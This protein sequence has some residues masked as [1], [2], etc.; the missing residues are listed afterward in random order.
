MVQS[1]TPSGIFEWIAKS[2]RV[3]TSDTA[4]LRFAEMESQADY[5]LPEIHQSLDHNDSRHWHHRG[6]IWDYISSLEGAKRVLDVGPGDGWP[7]L[8]L[9]RHFDEIVGIEPVQK[10]LDVC[11]AN[12]KKMKVRNVQFEQ[13]SACDMSF[14]SNSFDGAVAATSIEQTPDPLAALR[15]VHRVLKVGG[16]F[17]LSYEA[18]ENVAEPVRETVSIKAGAD[19]SYQI[20]YI[21]AWTDKAEERG[22]MINVI[23]RSENSKKRFMLWAERCKDD[24]F[25]HRDPRLERGLSRTIKG[26]RQAEVV[27]CNG[28]K[29]K[30]F[31][32]LPLIKSLSRIGFTNIRRVA[33]GGWP[34]MQSA[35]ELI[36]SR[37]IQAASPLMEE[38]CR[39][40]ARVGILLPTETHGQLIMTKRRAK[41]KTEVKEPAKGKA[42][43]QRKSAT[44]KTGVAKSSGTGAKTTKKTTKKVTKKTAGKTAAKTTR[45]TKP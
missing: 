12:A 24:S 22:Y 1:A 38:I 33:G 21:V 39:G 37:R 34:A 20:D 15:E 14:R 31:K 13:M 32:T 29:L 26:I 2:C 41:V 7:S 40:G 6:M 3:Q 8:L 11:R 9:A 44:R 4:T 23:P 25:P 19:D 36:K 43:P 5:S 35:E 42:K 16:T 10:R 30:H 18:L 17:R 45:A 28:Y 27:S